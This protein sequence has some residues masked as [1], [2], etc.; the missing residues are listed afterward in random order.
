MGENVQILYELMRRYHLADRSPE[1]AQI[2][3]LIEWGRCS[4]T[5]SRAY[6][7]AIQPLLNAQEARM[8]GIAAYK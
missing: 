2:L 8:K 1:V 3:R 5:M 4:E 6:L 7:H